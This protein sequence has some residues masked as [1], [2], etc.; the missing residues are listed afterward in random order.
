MVEVCC[1]VLCLQNVCFSLTRWSVHVLW[2]LDPAAWHR[3]PTYAP[4]K[5]LV[6]SQ[7]TATMYRVLSRHTFRAVSSLLRLSVPHEP[8]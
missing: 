2:S 7:P 1:C 5:K 6:L 4:W 8:R 3:P